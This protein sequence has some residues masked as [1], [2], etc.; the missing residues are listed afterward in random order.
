MIDQI[1]AFNKQ[2]EQQSIITTGNLRIDP[3]SGANL[4]FGYD[5]EDY[6]V[7]KLI[8]TDVIRRLMFSI[9]V[10]S[11]ST[12][13]WK[14]IYCERHNISYHSAVQL[15]KGA[16]Y[17]FNSAKNITSFDRSRIISR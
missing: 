16:L 4:C 7:I 6:K 12:N 9:E 15:V 17:F 1:K 5:N 14:I 2:M 10:Y 13:C 11:L 8:T 3:A